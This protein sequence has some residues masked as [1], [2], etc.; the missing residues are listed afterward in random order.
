MKKYIL[1]TATLAIFAS[2]VIFTSCKKKEEA[3]LPAESYKL[4]GKIDVSRTTIATAT[5]TSAVFTITYNSGN[6]FGG[7]QSV[8]NGSLKLAGYTGITGRDTLAFFA[9]QGAGPA[10][11]YITAAN[12]AIG[13]TNTNLLYNYFNGAA[14]VFNITNYPFTNDITSSLKEGRGFFRI[15]QFPKYVYVLLDEVTRL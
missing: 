15:G 12:T 4:V 8:M 2:S 13:T 14:A 9:S 11:S 6:S 1:S 7:A 10:I 3:L 5:L